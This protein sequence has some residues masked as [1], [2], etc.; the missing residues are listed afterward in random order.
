VVTGNHTSAVI[1]PELGAAIGDFLGGC[2]AGT[3]SWTIN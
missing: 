3:A 2:P 1:K